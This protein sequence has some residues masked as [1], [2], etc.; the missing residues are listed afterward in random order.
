MGLVPKPMRLGGRRQYTPAALD[1]MALIQFAKQAGFSLQ[2]IR[3]L[4]QGQPGGPI[5]SRW[6]RMARRKLAELDAQSRQ[7]QTMR[8]LLGRALHC[9]CLDL[10]ECE[11]ALRAK[12]G[13]RPC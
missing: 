10:Q 2:E 5:S 9:R 3:L 7:I 4:I 13:F 6:E 1:R 8:R 11:K 12:S